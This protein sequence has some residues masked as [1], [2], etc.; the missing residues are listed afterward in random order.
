MRHRPARCFDIWPCW[1][2]GPLPPLC[3]RGTWRSLT[4]KT[5]KIWRGQT[6][7]GGNPVYTQGTPYNSQRL[8]GLSFPT[9]F[10][11][12]PSPTGY[13]SWITIL[14]VILVYDLDSSNTLVDRTAK[15]VL[16]QVDFYS[17]KS[18]FAINRLSY[19]TGINFDA[20]SNRLFVAD[21][22]SNRVLV[23]DVAMITDGENP[24]NVL[25][26]PNF[27]SNSANTSINGMRQPRGISYDFSNQRLF[28]SD[29]DNH[30]VLVYNLNVVTD[31]EN[32]VNVLG[33]FYD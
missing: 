18:G 8:E 1:G 30:R 4:D 20:G 32:A 26:Q 22:N 13:S 15:H 16:G 27:A 7:G 23:F 17:N 10:R 3:G 28:V 2:C 11:S 19:A 29:T 6:D 25:G 5:P 33:H 21:R 14:T 24:V 31:G 12:I 9:T